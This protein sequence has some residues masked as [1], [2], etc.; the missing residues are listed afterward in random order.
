MAI[1]SEKSEPK[2]RYPGEGF[3]ENAHISSMEQYKRIYKRSVE[4]PEGFWSEFIS[5]FYFK[6]GPTGSFLKYNF[7]I[8]KDPIEIKWMEG[9]ITNVTYNVVDRIIEKELGDR[10]AYIW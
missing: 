6:Q 9:A 1:S 10:I 4:D 2:I 7:D 8:T 5:D 3:K